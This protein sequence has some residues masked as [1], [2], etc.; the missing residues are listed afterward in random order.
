MT[1]GKISLLFVLFVIR[2][3]CAMSG[4]KMANQSVDFDYKSTEV[5]ILDWQY[6]EHGYVGNYHQSL[7]R[8]PKDIVDKGLPIGGG[9]LSG[10]MPV[11]DF[12]YVKWRIKATGEIREDKVDLRSRLPNDMNNHGI[13]FIVKGAQL[14]IFLV[15]PTPPH[16]PPFNDSFEGGSSWPAGKYGYAT[17]K[18]DLT[19]QEY[20]NKLQI[21]PSVPLFFNFK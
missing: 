7:P 5:D 10:G 14:Y 1:N 21:Y 15:P 17:I 11:G 16:T 13:H 2:T 19:A 18:N 4:Q 8:A 6:G 20:I 12:L 9:G 3:G